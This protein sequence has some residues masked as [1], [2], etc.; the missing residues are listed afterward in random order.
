[1]VFIAKTMVCVTRPMVWETN[2]LVAKPESIFFVAL[3]IVFLVK[4]G[5]LVAKTLVSGIETRVWVMHTIVATPETSVAVLF[6]G[7]TPP[8]R[9]LPLPD[10]PV[11]PAIPSV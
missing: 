10:N 2:T 6:E 7:R 1:M 5:F 9:S 3:K 11:D 4:K 8:V